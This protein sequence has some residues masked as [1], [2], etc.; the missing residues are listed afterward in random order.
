VEL[1]RARRRAERCQRCD[2][3]IPGSARDH[4]APRRGLR[5]LLRRSRAETGGGRRP[6]DQ[7]Q[8]AEHHVA[9][10]LD[11]RAYEND[12][13]LRVILSANEPLAPDEDDEGSR[14]RERLDR[15]GVVLAIAYWP[16]WPPPGEGDA[17]ESATLPLSIDR[18]DL[19]GTSPG[20]QLLGEANAV[21]STFAIAR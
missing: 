17:L 13:G 9:R 8:R 15:D 2:D 20:D 10:R 3:H 21:V 7:R 16:D 6:N 1:A 19:G 14:T 12:T 5:S 18:S 11:G 4:G